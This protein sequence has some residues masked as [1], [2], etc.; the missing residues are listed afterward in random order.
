MLRT[1]KFIHRSAV[2]AAVA[3][4]VG[5]LATAA[6]ADTLSDLKAQ[7]EAQHCPTGFES[8]QAAGI[9]HDAMN[10]VY[11]FDGNKTVMNR[12]LPDVK[13]WDNQFE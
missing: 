9:D 12:V 4:A 2:G 11:F 10:R 3:M 5:I 1:R 7:L 8:E 6:R 13:Y